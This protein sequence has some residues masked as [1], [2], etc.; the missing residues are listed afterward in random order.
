ML[1]ETRFNPLLVVLSV[2]VAI[3]ASYVALNLAHSVTSTRGRPRVIWLTCG[4]L[5]MGVGIW[6]MHFVG[7]L[8]FEM[9]GMAMAYDIPLM[10]LS[11]LVAVGASALALY[12][13]SQPVVPMTS[14]IAGG[15]VMAVGIAGM[16]YIGMYSMRMDAVIEWNFFLILLSVMIALGASF[17]AL[18]ILVE[19]RDK[20]DRLLPMSFAS[21]IMGF[22]IAGMHY[23]GMFAATFYHVDS[24]QIRKEDLLVTDNLTMMVIASTL[25]ILG[26]AL[27]GS[28]GHRIISRARK[29]SE[30]VLVASEERYRLLIEAVKD[31]AIIM[32][33]SH[34][35]ITSWNTGAE[36]LTGYSHREVLGKHFSLFYTPEDL[37]INFPAE[38][39]RLAQVQGHFEAEGLRIRKDKST[40]LANVIITPVYDSE[41]R[42]TG[43]S[44]V[45]RDITALKEAESRMLRLNEDLE[46]RIESR[47]QALKQ[48]ETQ[49]RSI[50]N[51]LP[52]LVAQVDT[53]E[54]FT[55]A[56]EILCKWFS[57]KREDIVGHTLLEVFGHDR[58]QLVTDYVRRALSGEV[59]NYER[60]SRSLDGTSEEAT[61]SVTYVPEFDAQNQVTGFVL[62]AT[63]ITKHKEIESELKNARDAAEVANRTK[64]AFL[65][66]MSHEIR[67]PLGAV[68]G[69]S[70]LLMGD[71]TTPE[72]RAHSIEVIKRNGTLLSNIINDILDLSKVEAGKL[73]VEKIDVKLNELISEL[74][75]H[76]H[77]AAKKNIVLNINPEGPLPSTIK[78]DPVRLRQILMNIIGNAIKFTKK[79]RVDVTI[80]MQTDENRQAQLMFI[81]KDTGEGIKPEQIS[82]LFSPFSQADVSTTR[83]FGGT[84]LGLILSKKLANSL[85]GDIVLKESTFTV[86]STFIVTIDPGLSSGAFDAYPSH[87]FTSRGGV[88]PE[89]IELKNLKVLVVDDSPENILLI[90][91]FLTIAQAQV[92]TATNGRDAITMTLSGEYDVVLMDLQMPI[93]DGYQ[94]TRELRKQNYKSPIIALTAHAMVED[95]RR[96]L[97]NGFDD[98]ITKPVDRRTLLST[99]EKLKKQKT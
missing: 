81:V 82:K 35:H 52:V 18:K 72:E 60:T 21:T 45:K 36:K 26:L 15:I 96:C 89:T 43:F 59:V 31:Y 71:D 74:S 98:H 91:T 92:D 42:L 23:T 7:M 1:M 32:L 25:L 47:T 86:G 33:D 84:G 8:A 53:K 5:A 12:I 17:A 40:F 11:I 56:N 63:D 29:E 95:R 90:K 20:S 48:R 87:G 37:A 65:A 28:V 62:V 93:M 61:F 80:K 54:R 83:R 14:I 50:T 78:T 67:T 49:L 34:G 68:L 70:E 13:V 3:F 2:F 88:D 76:H 24:H 51:A 46:N 64:S 58:Y 66:N 75:L 4:A 30:K 97:E 27:I 9:P 69:F 79:G 85:G 39:L 94:A 77:E 6:S 99:L 73:E 44:E 55:F 16:H 41:K 57:L 22:A 10:I 19:L 38:E